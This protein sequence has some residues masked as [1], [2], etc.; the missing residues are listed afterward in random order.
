VYVPLVFTEAHKQGLSVGLKN[1]VEQ[2]GALHSH[3]DWALNEECLDYDE[4]GEYAPFINDGKVS[5]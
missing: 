1:D 2:I 5:L 4:C 3:F